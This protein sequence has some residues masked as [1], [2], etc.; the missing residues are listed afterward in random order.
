[1]EGEEREAHREVQSWPALKKEKFPSS[2]ARSSTRIKCLLEAKW[3]ASDELLVSSYVYNCA[4]GVA[5]IDTASAPNNGVTK[6]S[7]MTV[8]WNPHCLYSR[9]PH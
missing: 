8:D 7:G 6:S 2:A 5:D 1:M 4:S 9:R 3:E